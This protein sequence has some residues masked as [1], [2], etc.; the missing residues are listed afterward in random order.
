VQEPDT[1]NRTVKDWALGYGSGRY[2]STAFAMDDGLFDMLIEA[3][4]MQGS[5]DLQL[6]L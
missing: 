4:E 3:N 5:A 6:F 1:K 2:V